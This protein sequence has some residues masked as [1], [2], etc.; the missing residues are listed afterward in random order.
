VRDAPLAGGGDAPRPV[1]WTWVILFTV[2]ATVGI[3]LHSPLLALSRI[4]VVGAVQSDAV[5][6]IAGAG[7]GEGALLLWVNTGR[8]E[9]AVAE[10]PWVLRVSA[11]RVWPNRLVVEVV[12][13]VPAVGIE[14]VS[15]WMM[16]SA[17]G[18]VLDLA[19]RPTPDLVRAAVPFPDRLRGHRPNDAM[20]DEIVAMAV[21]LDNGRYMEALL[22]MRG[23]EMWTHIGGFE[24]RFGHPTDLADKARALVAI[25]AEDLPPGSRIDVSSPQRPALVPPDPEEGVEG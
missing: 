20:W 5:S 15:G 21:I 4:E 17:D 12:E 3:L 19:P 9:N 2:V 22:E 13:R 25:L 11:E 14:G 24:V 18:V 6:R 7:V 16:V 8:V 1:S 10:D 23:T